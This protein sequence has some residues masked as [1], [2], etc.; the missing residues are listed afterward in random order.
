M[1]CKRQVFLINCLTALVSHD[2]LVKAVHFVTRFW[3]GITTAKPTPFLGIGKIAQ[4]FAKG[5][6]S[7]PPPRPPRRTLNF[8]R[9]AARG[10]SIATMIVLRGIL[11]EAVSPRSKAAV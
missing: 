9:T 1:I 4:A 5:I 8:A 11:E 7:P 3:V 2:A 10:L 6:E